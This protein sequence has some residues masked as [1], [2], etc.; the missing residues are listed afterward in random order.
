MKNT[1]Y[2]LRNSWCVL[3]VCLIWKMIYV[4]VE[5]VLPS[6]AVGLKMSHDNNLFKDVFELVFINEIPLS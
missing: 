1:L 4:S 6:V 3:D 5:N 2:N